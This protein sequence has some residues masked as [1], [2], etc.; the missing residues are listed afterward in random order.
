[1][2]T[3]NQLL[4]QFKKE[5][6][7]LTED[8]SNLIR[9]LLIKLGRIEYEHYQ[10]EKLSPKAGTMVKFRDIGKLVEIDKSELKTA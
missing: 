5:G 3:A 8:E 1:M 9:T 4:I 2:I 10:S 6:V 7:I